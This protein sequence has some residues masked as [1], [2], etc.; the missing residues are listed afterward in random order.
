M[1]NAIQLFLTVLIYVFKIV[2]MDFIKYLYQNAPLAL[3]NAQLAATV[4]QIVLLAFMGQSLLLE[5]A[6]LNVDKMK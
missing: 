4:Q 3:L 6:V 2:L 1:E 5:H